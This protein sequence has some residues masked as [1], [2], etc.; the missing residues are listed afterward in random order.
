LLERINSGEY[1]IVDVGSFDQ[2]H[3]GIGKD[4][5]NSEDNVQAVTP[6]SFSSKTLE[7]LLVKVDV[8]S[9]P[10]PQTNV[11]DVV[12]V[13]SKGPHYG[14][15][16]AFVSDGRV[17]RTDLSVKE[18]WHDAIEAA[19]YLDL[20]QFERGKI[21]EWYSFNENKPSPF[22]QKVVAII[23]YARQKGILGEF[24]E[25]F[26]GDR[27]LRGRWRL[28]GDPLYSAIVTPHLIFGSRGEVL[29]MRANP[30]E[31]NYRVLEMEITPME[32]VKTD[33]GYA[34]FGIAYL[35][36]VIVGKHEVLAALPEAGLQPY[37]NE[38]KEMIIRS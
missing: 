34:T 8:S 3:L 15:C 6:P 23:E 33:T 16:V 30:D 7:N 24:F 25:T 10:L 14:D 9:T 21:P 4:P 2:P 28:D 11:G 32:G 36:K 19:P 13:V 35:R 20:Y 38:V 37:A 17:A 27:N 29:H 12:L 18:T 22:E 5:T 1:L 31:P 26:K